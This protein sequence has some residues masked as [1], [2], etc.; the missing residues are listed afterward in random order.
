[1]TMAGKFVTTLAPQIVSLPKWPEE[2][3]HLFVQLICAPGEVG[4][5]GGELLDSP[6][7]PTWTSLRIDGITQV[8][9]DHSHENIW[10]SWLLFSDQNCSTP[11]SYIPL[12]IDI[13]N[14]KGDLEGAYNLTRVCLD[15]YEHLSRYSTSIGL[16]VIFSGLKGFHIEARSTEPVDNRS[17]REDLLNGLA[18]IGKKNRGASNYFQDGTID[19]G[20]EFVRLS[21]SFNIWKDGNILRRRKVIQ[22]SPDEF[23]VLGLEK[24]LQQSEAA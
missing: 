19:P 16:R 13:D 4:F 24:I 17:F 10:R 20:H 14:E 5:P 21:G 7:P 18:Q 9:R 11:V 1:M 22:M 2:C 8:L 6:C 23:R 15:W 3:P 12:L